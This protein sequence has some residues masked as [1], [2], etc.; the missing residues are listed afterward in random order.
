MATEEDLFLDEST[1]R[2]CLQIPILDD[3]VVENP[4]DLQVL[5][6][7]PDPDVMIVMPSVASVII[8]DDDRAV[9]GFEMLAY[10]VNESRGYVEV[11]A[12]LLE[13]SLEISVQV[14]LVTM[15]ITAESKLIGGSG[16]GLL[17]TYRVHV[18][19]YTDCVLIQHRSYRSRV[20]PS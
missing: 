7:S 2:A 1:A 16:N 8:L 15:D 11:C 10:S 17:N 18:C 9:I 13:G 14:A 6:S 12:A 5:I 3:E 20:S 19:A 4:E